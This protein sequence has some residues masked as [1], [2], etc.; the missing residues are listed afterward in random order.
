[1]CVVLQGM[2]LVASCGQVGFCLRGI[3]VGEACFVEDEVLIACYDM[4]YTDDFT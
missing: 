3:G 4:P 1:M 2:E